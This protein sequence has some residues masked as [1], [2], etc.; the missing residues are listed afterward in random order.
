MS[1]SLPVLACLRLLTFE[2]RTT[3]LFEADPFLSVARIEPF[4][5]GF[6]L[7]CPI[8]GYISTKFRMLRLP[9]FV[10]FL[11]F[12]AGIVGFA[13]IQPDENFRPLA[14]AALAGVGIGAPLI[15]IVSGTQL[16][17]PHQLIATATAVT[18]SS[19]SVGATVFTAIYAAALNSGLTSKLPTYIAEA[20]ATA[21]LPTSS[22]PAFVGALAGDDQAA[23]AAVPG[24]TPAIIAQGVSALHHAYADSLRVIY[25]IA[26]PFG[27]LACVL[28]FF[29]SDL[30]KT[31]TYRVDAPVEDLHAKHHHA[32]THAE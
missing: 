5:V 23:L 19:R 13:T 2:N 30:K 18:V 15:L 12:T 31:M 11:L 16:S 9:L 21:G 4:W 10:G 25:I 3:S 8:Y 32:G 22:I 1:F 17:T 14:F 20:A 28:C 29:L 24:V 26:A 6:L 7:S 27:I